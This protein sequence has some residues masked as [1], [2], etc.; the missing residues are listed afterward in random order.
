MY[1]ASP[2]GLSTS[3]PASGSYGIRHQY[4][5]MFTIVIS[6]QRAGK[7]AHET[8]DNRFPSEAPVHL[9]E[10]IEPEASQGSNGRFS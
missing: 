1:V 9:P 2:T 4:A 6:R 8:R 5:V 3:Y 7:G 10:I